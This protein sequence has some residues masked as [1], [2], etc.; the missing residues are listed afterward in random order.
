MKSIKIKALLLLLLHLNQCTV[1]LV[2]KVKQECEERRLADPGSIIIAGFLIGFLLHNLFMKSKIIHWKDDQQW[3]QR[4]LEI[5]ENETFTLSFMNLLVDS[6]SMELS[7]ACLR[8]FQQKYETF[9][10]LIPKTIP[11][12][13]RIDREA[14]LW[15]NLMNNRQYCVNFFKFVLSHGFITKYMMNANFAMLY[16]REGFINSH[17]KP[18]EDLILFLNELD[19]SIKSDPAFKMIDK[20][21]QNYFYI[22][23]NYFL[24][25]NN[26]LKKLK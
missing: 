8:H 18:S 9:M 19:H 4:F 21:H 24:D 10:D 16:F 3:E 7:N 6:Y 22:T 15:E 23:V 2:K 17:K 1:L 14:R 25:S 5:T 13:E 12:I 26:E 11:R 20:T